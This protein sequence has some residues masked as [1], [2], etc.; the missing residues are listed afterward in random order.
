LKDNKA[1]ELQIGNPV[2]KTLPA[3]FLLFATEKVSL[4]KQNLSSY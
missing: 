3:R 1:G 2:G 4:L